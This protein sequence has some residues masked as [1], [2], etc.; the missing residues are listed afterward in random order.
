MLCWPPVP[1]VVAYAWV[2]VVPLVESWRVNARAYAPSQLMATRLTAVAAPRSTWN[3]WFGVKA[4]DQRVP[5]LP[6]TAAAAGVPAHSTDEAVTGLPCETTTSAALAGVV[7]V[8][9]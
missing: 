9:T 2:Q 6:S 4:L 5:V 7:V 1:V 3:H 8:A